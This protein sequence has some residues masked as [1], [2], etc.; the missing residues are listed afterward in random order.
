MHGE[1]RGGTPARRTTDCGGDAGGSRRRRFAGA[2]ATA[3][4]TTAGLALSVGATRVLCLAEPLGTAIGA[5]DRVR[6]LAVL[7]AITVAVG[8][9]LP[10]AT[11]ARRVASVLTLGLLFA[12][13]NAL[14]LTLLAYFHQP[15]LALYAYLPRPE[16][17]LATLGTYWT[18]VHQYVS[19]SYVI[20]T[21]L[22]TTPAF[23]A[24]YV[25]R[26]RQSAATRALVAASLT[27]AAVGPLVV[28]LLGRSGPAAAEAALAALE[29]RVDVKPLYRADRSGSLA[30][31]GPP[32][33]TPRTIVL[34]VN[35]STGA[36]FRSSSSA[37]VSLGERLAQLSGAPDAWLIYRNAVTNSSCSDVSIPS[38]LTGSG[39]DES[40][41][42]LHAL[43]LVVDLAHARGYR[44][45]FYTSAV[46][47]WANLSTFI[48]GGHIDE[49]LTGPM[50]GRPLI[51]DLATDDIPV[52]RQLA[53]RIRSAGADEPLFIVVY[54][55]AMHV[56]YQ[57]SGEIAFPPG[58]DDRRLRGL[59]V[60]ETEHQILFDA[61]RAAGRFADA[62]II[63]T[64][65]HGDELFNE[66]SSHFHAVR[67]ENYGEETLRPLFM[68][69]PPDDLPAA[70]AGPLRANVDALVANLDIAPTLADLL[71]LQLRD[72]L[73]YTGLSLFSPIPGDR[74][75]AA[76]STNEWRAWPRPAVALARGNERFTCDARDLCRFY[77][78]APSGAEV[79]SADDKAKVSAYMAEALTRPL[80]NQAIAQLYHDR[81]QD[82]W[83]TAAGT[84]VVDARSARTQVAE[85][86][87]GADGHARAAAAADH[88]AGYV[89]YGP[90]WQ[91][92][93]GQ[94]NA[95]MLIALGTDDTTGP[96]RPPCNLDVFDGFGVL[97]TV[98]IS[99]AGAR[100]Q[101]VS[102]PFA[103]PTG[104]VRRYE[105][106]LWCDAG[107]PVTVDRI[108]FVR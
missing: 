32:R 7:A 15:L 45:I 57:H 23:G 33:A 101:R 38:L 12:A 92:P 50:T 63:E 68:V 73:R 4:L 62:L 82:M 72:G 44:T 81:L 70:M 8:L 22:C 104:S 49:L 85:I 61:L 108:A 99:A 102:V 10:A 24:L 31:A 39:T 43:P 1:R 18:Y 66:A 79:S 76:T 65:D 37:D 97:G 77:R 88:P 21:V 52:M 60:L 100:A 55:N 16:H 17:E 107:V 56:P 78:V 29:P 9:I 42:K 48:A 14:D 86:T 106:R 11:R 89:T 5:P 3:A 34:V 91:L 96:T 64:G 6:Y 98:A 25:L 35:E 20:A 26:L 59:F 40:L 41:A 19:P 105:A 94:Y 46:I 53:D 83:A 54:P 28:A 2:L 74:V 51:T 58:M 80:I 90:Y 95:E 84:W 75:S 27:F 103:V 13:L 30:I 67:V 93:S 36:F 47:E 87:A 71:N 69:K